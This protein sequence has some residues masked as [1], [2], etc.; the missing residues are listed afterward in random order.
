MPL[1]NLKV[2]HLARLSPVMHAFN[3]PF[4][5]KEQWLPITDDMQGMGNYVRAD[6][7]PLD[8]RGEAMW[9]NLYR[10]GAAGSLSRVTPFGP[11][12]FSGCSG[13]GQDASEPTGQPS[14]TMGLFNIVA[15]FG[16]TL[17][18]LWLMGR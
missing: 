3:E 11:A 5:R 12:A 9:S 17:G 13:C 4:I 18:A 15:A 2:R 1:K 6:G 7:T 10:V 16:L 8:P 14:S